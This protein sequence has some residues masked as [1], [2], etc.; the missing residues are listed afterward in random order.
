M[1]DSSDAIKVC[2]TDN[3]TRVIAQLG[4]A[5]AALNS[6]ST[7]AKG[8]QACLSSS[9]LQAL[10][11]CGITITNL[12]CA[13]I[14]VTQSN[15]TG[16]GAV[17]F[18]IAVDIAETITVTGVFN[19]SNSCI[20]GTVSAELGNTG[21][22]TETFT[23]GESDFVNVTLAYTTSSCSELG[24]IGTVTLTFITNLG[25]EY[26]YTFPVSLINASYIIIDGVF[27]VSG[28][29]IPSG[30]LPEPVTIVPGGCNGIVVDTT[31]TDAAEPDYLTIIFNATANSPEGFSPTRG[32]LVVASE[33][34]YYLFVQGNGKTPVTYKLVNYFGP[35][36]VIFVVVPPEYDEY[37]NF[38]D[39]LSLTIKDPN[40]NCLVQ[41]NCS[42]S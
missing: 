28:C 38:C 32:G 17:S 22:S 13:G 42:A 30:T 29:V 14:S 25:C 23:A 31:W 1:S 21:G 15:N 8:L 6:N 7:I 26:T 39:N 16:E 18:G 20:V 10:I 27:I 4:S 24:L 40:G 2:P 41:V 9:E 36:H 35:N 19:P 11:N 12:G 3:A 37:F 5:C 33:Y 34:G